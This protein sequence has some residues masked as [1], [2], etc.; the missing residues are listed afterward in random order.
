MLCGMFNGELDQFRQLLVVLFQEPE[1]P[2]GL[3]TGGC[4][5]GVGEFACGE[6][7]FV[8][9]NR[10]VGRLGGICGGFR[11]VMRLSIGCQCA[12]LFRQ[13]TAAR[14]QYLDHG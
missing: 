13:A 8:D 6:G 12:T 3:D 14:V 9:G 10:R 4:L 1:G 5:S 11:M 2:E 7:V